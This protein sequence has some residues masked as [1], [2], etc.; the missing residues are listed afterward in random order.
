MVALPQLSLIKREYLE[1]VGTVPQ[2]NWA[3]RNRMSFERYCQLTVLAGII[4]VFV[5]I[6]V[7]VL[8]I[9]GLQ[10]QKS[11]RKKAARKEAAKARGG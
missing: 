4:L 6:A 5:I 9:G 8:G 2:K 10:L 1:G 3:A 7:L 11:L